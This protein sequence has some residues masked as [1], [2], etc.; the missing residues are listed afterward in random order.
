ME[1]REL[2]LADVQ[3][4]ENKL[5]CAVR[6]LLQSL[7]I[8]M[9]SSADPPISSRSS[10]TSSEDKRQSIYRREEV[11]SELRRSSALLRRTVIPSPSRRKSRSS[12][13]SS[14][15]S[16]TE[17]E[18][19]S[20][21]ESIHSTNEEVTVT[22]PEPRHLADL[23]S[24]MSSPDTPESEAEADVAA[25]YP[26]QMPMSRCLSNAAALMNSIIEECE[27]EDESLS[28]PISVNDTDTEGRCTEMSALPLRD[29]TNQ[30]SLKSSVPKIRNVDSISRTK[31]NESD[32]SNQEARCASKITT[33]RGKSSR[34]P[35]Q[36]QEQQRIELVRC[37]PR[38][39]SPIHLSVPGDSLNVDATLTPRRTQLNFS[40]FNGIVDRPDDCST[41]QRNHEMVNSERKTTM[42]AKPRGKR[43]QS[44]VGCS[45]NRTE[46]SSW[47]SSALGRPS[48]SCRPKSLK[49]ISRK[50][51]MRNESQ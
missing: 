31:Q 25:A 1:E 46:E 50:I 45:L 49:E 48:R 43:T 13:T 12:S 26:D 28:S 8:N 51:K 42:R 27:E 41:P 47:N 34:V 38:Q 10:Q 40:I 11:C 4:N 9:D 22:T 7:D 21:K 14:V 23:Q 39:N 33:A 5:K 6:T 16:C 32:N 2:R 24:N 29:V 3:Y 15:V 35:I 44:T 18:E 37:A 20:S 17:E 30:T 19:E 36:E